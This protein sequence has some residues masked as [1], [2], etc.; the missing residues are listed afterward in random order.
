MK[1]RAL[2]LIVLAVGRLGAEDVVFEGRPLVRVDADGKDTKL[3]ELST[4]AGIKYACRI[5]KRGHTYL[6]ANREN[7]KLD[8]V[9]SGD[10]TYYISPEGSGY[11]KVL[12]IRQ[13]D[14]EGFD[15]IE[16]VTA[17][18]KTVTY[19]GR[20]VRESGAASPAP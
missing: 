9:P 13:R 1:L 19:W 8:R 3:T 11:V 4:S 2:L 12:E 6:W 17:G 7:R 18:F 14:A 16:H 20:A 10:F 15:Y 5:I